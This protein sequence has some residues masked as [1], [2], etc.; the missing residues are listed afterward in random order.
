MSTRFRRFLKIA[1]LTLLGGTLLCAAGVASMLILPSDARAL[2][3]E[4]I[5]AEGLSTHT[6]FQISLGACTLGATRLIVSQI[7]KVDPQAREALKA[8]DHV[9]VGI[10]SVDAAKPVGSDFSGLDARMESRGWKRFLCVREQAKTVIGYMPADP[11]DS[12]LPLCMAIHDGDQ[13]IIV[14]VKADQQPL[15]DLARKHVPEKLA[16]L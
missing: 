5:R 13:L 11:G 9:A 1:G 4:V 8:L 2:R 15:V 14:S 7:D 3:D 16:S 12:T 10:Y 6:K